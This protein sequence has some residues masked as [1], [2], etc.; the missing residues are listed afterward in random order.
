MLHLRS[1]TLTP[2]T[3][4]FDTTFMEMLVDHR[5]NKYSFHMCQHLNRQ[6]LLTKFKNIYVPINVANTHWVFIH[7]ALY[8]PFKVTYYDSLNIKSTGTIFID[9]I[10]NY[11]ED[12][13]KSIGLSD[14]D[15]FKANNYFK[16]INGYKTIN[17]LQNNSYD[18]GVYLITGIER[19]IQGIKEPIKREEIPLERIRIRNNLFE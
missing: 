11:I 17:P 12:Y 7:I 9:H 19:H 16:N 3:L 1:I 18:C 15:R 6:H 4:I 8:Y 13:G 14:D 2:D 5:F 10:L